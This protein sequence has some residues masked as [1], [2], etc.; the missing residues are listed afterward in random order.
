MKRTPLFLLCFWLLGCSLVLDWS[1]EGAPCDA[2]K[3]CFS[4]FLCTE[5]ACR[6]IEKPSAGPGV[7]KT[8]SLAMAR[9]FHTA[10]AIQ[11]GKV[12]V[13][14][15]MGAS[16]TWL[17]TGEL[18]DFTSRTW[19]PA[20]SLNAFRAQHAAVLLHDDRVLVVGGRAGMGDAALV[21]TNEIFDPKLGQFSSA[22]SLLAGRTFHGVEVLRTEDA[23]RVVVAGGFPLMS[24]TEEFNPQAQTW[25]LANPMKVPRYGHR[26]IRYG[27]QVFA[28]G[29]RNDSAALSS[30]EVLDASSMAWTLESDTLSSPRFDFTATS[31]TDGRVLVVGGA[32]LSGASETFLNTTELFDPQARKWKKV[33]NLAVARARHAAAL[34]PDGKVIV[35]GGQNMTGPLDSIEVFD[36]NTGVWSNA[37]SL[38]VSR[39]NLTATVLSD[40]SVLLVGGEGREGPT[41]TV[42]LYVP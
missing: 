3:P 22:G 39:Q 42:D 17:K 11:G 4:G 21:T 36:P 35:A 7:A 41:A 31:L 40:G 23:K 9:T 6:S 8:N 25:S 34:L 37:G 14:G 29:G 16:N 12:L 30:V 1:G 20:P 15:G 33:G 32:D 24:S 27:T 38:S 18:F 13:L 26:L 28:I 5:G 2:K 19:E 10:T